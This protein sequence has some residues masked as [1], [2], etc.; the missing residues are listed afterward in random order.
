MSPERCQA[1]MAE[2]LQLPRLTALRQSL[3]PAGD[4]GCGPKIIL[5]CRPCGQAGPEGVARAFLEAPPVGVVLCSNRLCTKA[6]IEA[7]LLHELTHAWDLCNRRLD[8]AKCT[9]LAFSEVRGCHDAVHC[10]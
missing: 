2:V 5:S 3:S 1:L 4:A 9:D 10:T 8:F 7:A 6:E